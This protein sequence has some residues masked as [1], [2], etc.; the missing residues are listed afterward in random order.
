MGSEHDA[1]QKNLM[2]MRQVG[3]RCSE[4]IDRHE[5]A[6]SKHATGMEHKNGATAQRLVGANHKPPSAASAD[7]SSMRTSPAVDSFTFFEEGRRR[8]M[9]PS[10]CLEERHVESCH[11]ESGARSHDQHGQSHAMGPTS[12]TSPTMPPA[13]AK[14]EPRTLSRARIPF[15]DMQPSQCI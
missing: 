2:E 14:L 10:G 15:S 1:V 8:L 12:P 7:P 9:Q 3:I 4:I 6:T 13:N 5:G 11:Q